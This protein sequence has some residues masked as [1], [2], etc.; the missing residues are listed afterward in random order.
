MKWI[1]LAIAFFPDGTNIAICSKEVFKTEKECRA[2]AQSLD[3]VVRGRGA[4][5]FRF[6]CETT[7]PGEM[8]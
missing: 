8:A 2:K 3:A 5:A 7:T 6:Q 4:V 1:L